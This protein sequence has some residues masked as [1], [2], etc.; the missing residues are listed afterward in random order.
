MGWVPEIDH[1]VI[2]PRRQ[3]YRPM[4]KVLRTLAVKH[5]RIA[6]WTWRAILQVWVKGSPNDAVAGVCRRGTPVLLVI[7]EG[8]ARQFEPSVYWSA[9]RRRL[10]RKKL[11]DVD[12]VAGRDHSLY[13]RE[14]REQAYEIVTRWVV[15]HYGR[16]A[17]GEKSDHVG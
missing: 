8:D 15:S 2:D 5:A 6:R 12:F 9:V 14:A 1:G 11:L 7:S 4:P 17:R 16:S 10:R 13:T 3:A